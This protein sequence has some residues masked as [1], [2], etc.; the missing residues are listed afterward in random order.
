MGELCAA[1]SANEVDVLSSNGR[2][3]SVKSFA[4]LLSVELV[5]ETGSARIET[6]S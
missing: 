5:I 3:Q 6:G 4:V 1:S 2:S